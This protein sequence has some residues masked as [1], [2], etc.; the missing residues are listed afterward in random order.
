[1]VI[2]AALA[3]SPLASADDGTNPGSGYDALL[4]ASSADGTAA[5]LATS[6]LASADAT[7]GTSGGV[8]VVIEPEG[9]PTDVDRTP[10]IP[11]LLYHVTEDQEYANYAVV[12]GQDILLTPQNISQFPELTP[13][14]IGSEEVAENTY[15]TS[16]LFGFES[17]DVTSGSGDLAGDLG[18]MSDIVLTPFGEFPLFGDA[19]G[20]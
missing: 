17:T 5:A 18:N 1:V 2:A 6:P 10:I 7:D 16:F 11:G 8:L 20:V 13:A 14:D 3:V 12:N 19:H 4:G 9:P 15:I